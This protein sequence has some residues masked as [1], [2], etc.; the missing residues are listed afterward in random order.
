MISLVQVQKKVE[1][2]MDKT[3]K[4]NLFQV[5]MLSVKTN[6]LFLKMLLHCKH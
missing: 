3:M 2:K 6:F 4:S 1:I 5:E